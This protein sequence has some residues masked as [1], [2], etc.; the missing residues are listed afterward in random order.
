MEECELADLGF[1]GRWYTWERGRLA[2]NNIKERLDR[3]VANMA[4]W[5]KFRE[6]KVQHLLHSFFYHCPIL[7]NTVSNKRPNDRG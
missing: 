5:N 3:G 1:I 6:Y 7:I 4:W 2:L